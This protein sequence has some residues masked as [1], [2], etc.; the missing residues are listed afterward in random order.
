MSEEDKDKEVEEEKEPE[1]EPEI[2]DP[3]EALA[4]KIGWNPNHDGEGR[5]KLSAEEFI[6]KSREI[7]D[8]SS[9]QNKRLNREL[10]ELKNGFGEYRQHLDTLYQAQLSQRDAEISK[11]RRERRAANEDGDDQAV[12]DIDDQID[13][14]SK[15]PDKLP[16]SQ[17]GVL[18]PEFVQWLDDN[19]WYDEDNELRAYADMLGDQPEYRALG[20]KDY[21]AMLKQVGSTVKKMFPQKFGE[22]NTPQPRIPAA[23][24][25]GATPR[26]Q[27]KKSKYSYNDLSHDQKKNCDLFVKQ[28]IY[29]SADEYIA[30]L[31]KIEDARR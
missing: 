5:E 18:R 15:L 13:R 4:R 25:E 21:M 7:Q 29:K 2:E 10:M 12:R 14:M 6:L 28:G 17:Q 16:P 9:K 31:Q 8:T 19:D 24:V 23:S 20:Q 3:I 30:E 26:S 27:S 1:K 11:L 22:I